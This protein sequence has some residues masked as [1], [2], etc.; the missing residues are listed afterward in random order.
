MNF[1]PRQTEVG[2][3]FLTRR[4]LL[5]IATVIIG[6]TACSDS[7]GPNSPV[8]IVPASP[9]V[10]LQATQFGPAL[11][12]SVTVTNTSSHPVGYSSCGVSL[13]TEG[14]AVDPPGRPNWQSV[15]LRICYVLDVAGQLSTMPVS[16]NPGVIGLT[17]LQPGASVTIP[18]SAVVGEPANPGFT[19]EP[20]LYRF[21]VP[22]SV[23]LF[24]KFY[25]VSSD[26]SVSEPFAVIP[27][28]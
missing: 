4:G 22:V 8:Q 1:K 24:G 25:P 26:R 27:A 18:I 28:P 19:G 10:A 16:S 23:Q 20:G 9:S 5:A 17:I 3:R 12:T 14:L 7:T 11:N 21:R 6:G 2:T 15:W 13:E